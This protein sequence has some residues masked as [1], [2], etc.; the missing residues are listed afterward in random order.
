MAW[1]TG[2]PEPVV[3]VGP[4]G[5]GKTHFLELLRARW[6]E[7]GGGAKRLDMQRLPKDARLLRA[8]LEHLAS[9]AQEPPLLLL[10]NVDVHAPLH[11]VYSETLRPM[12]DRGVRVALTVTELPTSSAAMVADGPRM[13][14]DQVIVLRPFDARESAAYLADHGIGDVPHE[15]LSE[16]SGGLPLLLSTMLEFAP[17]GD[18][19]WPASD[20]RRSAVEGAAAMALAEAPTD[21]H[22]RGLWAIALPEVLSQRLLASMLDHPR[23]NE[24]YRW[25]ASRAYVAAGDDGLAVH[26]LFRGPLLD[27][28]MLRSQHVYRE[29]LLRAGRFFIARADGHKLAEDRCR[30]GASLFYLQRRQYP[31]SA[32]AQTLVTSGYYVD[33]FAPGDAEV[34]AAT[35]R[36]FEGSGSIALAEHWRKHAPSGLRVFRDGEGQVR[37][38]VQ[39]L[40]LEALS[41]DVV[42]VDPVLTR[43]REARDQRSQRRRHRRVPG[44]QRAKRQTT[45]VFRHWLDRDLGPRAGV[46]RMEMMREMAMQVLSMP[47]PGLVMLVAPAGDRALAAALQDTGL[48]WRYDDELQND[49]QELVL[50]GHDFTEEPRNMWLRRVFT[51]AING[52]RRRSPG[53]SP[54]LAPL[55]RADFQAAVVDALRGYFDVSALA[56]NP[57][58]SLVSTVDNLSE[59]PHARETP[60]QLWLEHGVTRLE[61]TPGGQVYAAQIRRRFLARPMLGGAANDRELAT[62]IDLLVAM[63]WEAAAPTRGPASAA[64]A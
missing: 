51:H 33:D 63:L 19:G 6:Q 45:L 43:V 58:A 20:P 2:G 12:L 1:L 44:R 42:A 9:G 28:L 27:D 7:R 56:S 62:A 59:P 54:G 31:L 10:D 32:L 22:R 3:I 55:A 34:V 21:E 39:T 36:R 61:G 23:S 18:E 46:G 60:L 16:V 17:D 4:G 57:L 13:A 47:R 64:G 40:V 24:V 30:A 26:M 5:V 53:P 15:R 37:A 8:R 49:G 14:G 38:F 25:L 11:Q 41:P 52:G 35:V 48:A 29:F 50:F